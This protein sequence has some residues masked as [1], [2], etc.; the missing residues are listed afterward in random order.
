MDE[1]R[2]IDAVRPEPH[3]ASHDPED[4]EC[5]QRQQEPVAEPEADRGPEHRDHGAEPKEEGDPGA[6]I[7]ELLDDRADKRD[8]EE[9]GGVG[10]G[11]ARVPAV[12]C[13]PLLVAGVQREQEQAGAD[14]DRDV[15]AERVPERPAPRVRVPQGEELPAREAT[16]DPEDDDPEQDRVD[17]DAADRRL[18]AV[19]DVLGRLA[20]RRATG[21]SER[22]E[23]GDE[24]QPGREPA[25]PARLG[26]SPLAFVPSPLMRPLLMPP[27]LMPPIATGP[28]AP[29]RRRGARR[30][31]P[32]E[33]HGARGRAPR[34]ASTSRSG[35]STSPNR[36]I[37]SS[38]QRSE[39]NE[40]GIARLRSAKSP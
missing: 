14:E 19:E 7:E 29:R 40:S 10:A 32:S 33:R 35:K 24:E 5:R 30:R 34:A 16:A 15:A 39:G 27:L 1:H 6:A 36:D 17:D 13:Q 9:V 38:G 12:G 3:D 11:A 20:A 23:R 28:I 4:D 25:A 21:V 37:E 22:R 18:V 26:R 2:G 8:G 31:P